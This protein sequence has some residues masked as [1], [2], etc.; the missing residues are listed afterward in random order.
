MLEITFIE[1]QLFSKGLNE[2]VHDRV[3]S[4]L[5]LE[6]TDNLYYF[7]AEIPF[8]GAEECILLPSNQTTQRPFSDCYSKSGLSFISCIQ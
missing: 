3:C 7:Y 5:S 4:D 2:K 1:N 8:K 6:V